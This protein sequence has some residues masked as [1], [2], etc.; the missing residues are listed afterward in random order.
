MGILS[1]DG[2]YVSIYVNCFIVFVWFNLWDG[3]VEMKMNG[4]WLVLRIFLCYYYY[5]EFF[6]VSE[7]FL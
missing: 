5:D 6:F 4:K 3:L 2:R 1:G 7:F